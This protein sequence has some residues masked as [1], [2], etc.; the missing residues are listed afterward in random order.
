MGLLEDE[1]IKAYAIFGNKS[2]MVDNR[3]IKFE[4]AQCMAKKL[5]LAYFETSCKTR[6]GIEE[7]FTYVVNEIYEKLE[8]QRINKI[9]LKE[10]ETKKVSNSNCA[11]KKKN[12]K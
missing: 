11:G 3:K 7:G 8:N 2:D 5:G 10:K 6:E 1:E 9:N 4:E 12:K